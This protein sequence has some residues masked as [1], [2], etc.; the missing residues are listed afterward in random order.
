MRDYEKLWNEQYPDKKKFFFQIRDEFNATHQPHHLLYL[1]ARIVKGS[2]RYSAEGKFNQSADNRRWGMR[3]KTMR[4]QIF[5]VST[6]LAGETTLSAVDFRMVAV[7]ASKDDL[8]YMDPPYQGIS[9]TRDHRY[10]NGLSYDEFID[11]LQIMNGKDI[12]YIISYDGQTGGKT[13]GKL[14]PCRLSL[15]HLKIHAGRSS[16]A[17][18]LGYNHETVESLYLSPAL[19]ERLDGEERNLEKESQIQPSPLQLKKALIE[20]YGARCNIYLEPFPERELQIDHR[21]PF[22]I[23]GENVDLDDVNEYMLLCASANRAKSWS[24]EH[25]ENW[26]KREVSICESCYWAYPESYSH[27]A[28]RD[29]RRLDILW[30][31]EDIVEYDKLRGEAAKAQEEVPQY[32]KNVLRNHFK[33]KNS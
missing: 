11:T 31:D 20:R 6:L 16:Q 30:T 28:T 9:F 13:H 14:L 15:K 5:G 32:V 26:K 21:V 1:L 22:E 3:P 10:Y 25:C 4:Q 23:A 27:I 2:V 24:C 29:I 8:V 12:S 17:T 7:K 33:R 19:A 18:L